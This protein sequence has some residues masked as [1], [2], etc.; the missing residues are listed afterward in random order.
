VVLSRNL[1]WCAGSSL[2][3]NVVTYWSRDPA[4]VAY[5]RDL[6]R[7]GRG[8]CHVFD[9]ESSF[10]RTISNGSGKLAAEQS[11]LFVSPP[12]PQNADRCKDGACLSLCLESHVRSCR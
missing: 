6:A 2:I 7:L 12:T 8:R 4:L 3:I 5:A 10:A 1:T 11:V 9:G